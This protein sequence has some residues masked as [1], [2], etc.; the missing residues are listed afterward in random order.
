MHDGGD[1]GDER[2]RHG[3]HLVAGPDAGGDERQVQRVIAAADADGV[4]HADKGGEPLL[5]IAKLLPHDEIA[6][7]QRVDNRV[8]EF[9]SVAAIVL[10]RVD[11][12]NFVRQE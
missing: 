6:A 4:F 12:R 8:L 7:R 5:E 3:N 10:A 11:E 1:G 9:V 2:V